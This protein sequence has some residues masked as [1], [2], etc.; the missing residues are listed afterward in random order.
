MDKR[1]DGAGGRGRV[2]REGWRAQLLMSTSCGLAGQDP[3][4]ETNAGRRDWLRSGERAGFPTEPACGF[5]RRRWDG[6]PGSGEGALATRHRCCRPPPPGLGQAVSAGFL[7]SE[8]TTFPFLINNQLGEEMLREQVNILLLL[9][10]LAL[11]S[12]P[13]L[14]WIILSAGPPPPASVSSF[15]LWGHRDS[16]ALPLLWSD[17]AHLILWHR[18]RGHPCP[19]PCSE[20]RL[21][22]APSLPSASQCFPALCTWRGSGGGAGGQKHLC[23]ENVLGSLRG[24]GEEWGRMSRATCPWYKCHTPW[25]TATLGSNPGPGLPVTHHTLRLTRSHRH[26]PPGRNRRYWSSP[27]RLESYG[28]YSKDHFPKSG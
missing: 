21:L 23:S 20:H 5:L 1:S 4:W 18:R 13:V 14:A 19:H 22:V 17:T 15:C 10:K 3:S 27:L 8:V 2:C 24:L 11:I 28:V 9:L 16:S 7:Q 26:P 12:A 6:A 25:C